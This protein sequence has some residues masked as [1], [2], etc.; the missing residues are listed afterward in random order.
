M[1][2]DTWATVSLSYREELL[3]TSSLKHWLY[4]KK[5][6]FAHPNG[7]PIKDR[8]KK[9]DAVAPDHLAAKKKI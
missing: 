8:L 3:Q 9:L 1:Q 4:Q 5:N 6:P 7:I 2:S